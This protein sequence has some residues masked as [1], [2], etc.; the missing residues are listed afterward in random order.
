[1]RT[2]E[3][4]I[5]VEV[6]QSGQRAVDAGAGDFQGVFAGDRV[7]GVHDLGNGARQLGA[8]LD[9][10]VAA[11]AVFLQR[12]FGHDLEAT[13]LGPAHQ[14]QADDLIADGFGDGIQQPSAVQH[15]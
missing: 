4:G 8:V 3:A 7:G 1:M 12:P 11:A 2:L 9:V 5:V 6:L 13:L 14:A 10:H 15:L